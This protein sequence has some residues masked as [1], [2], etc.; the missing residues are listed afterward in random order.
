MHVKPVSPFCTQG[1]IDRESGEIHLTFLADFNFS[2]DGAYSAPSLKISTSLTTGQVSGRLHSA[3][4]SRLD[5]SGRARC[6]DG[7]LAAS[8]AC[9]LQDDTP[10][11][12]H[13]GWWG[14]PRWRPPQTHS[15][16]PF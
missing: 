13:A 12:L 10:A 9:V 6:A 7:L 15:S 8:A 4:G 1:T 2:A 14:F 16:T 11:V 5:R 3:Q